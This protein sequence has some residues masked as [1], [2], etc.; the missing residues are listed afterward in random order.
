MN[1]QYKKLTVKFLLLYTKHCKIYINMIK[2]NTVIHTNKREKSMT[3]VKNKVLFILGIIIIMTLTSITISYGATP[4]ENNDSEYVYLSDI[5]YI[6]D[7]SFAP[8]GESILL[9]KNKA[10]DLITLKVNDKSKPFIKGICAWATSEIV[11]DLREY[12]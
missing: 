3:K 10:N 9:D 5:A 8:S 6:K 1:K 2:Y 4:K 7:K 12:D 11:Y